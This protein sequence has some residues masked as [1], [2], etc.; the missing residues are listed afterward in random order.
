LL[1]GVQGLPRAAHPT[2]STMAWD[3]INNMNKIDRLVAVFF[4]I[5]LLLN[6]FG[7]HIDGRLREIPATVRGLF[8]KSSSSITH[9]RRFTRQSTD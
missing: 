9:D 4:L 1:F 6:Q 8:T 7:C 5:G 3:P 2:A